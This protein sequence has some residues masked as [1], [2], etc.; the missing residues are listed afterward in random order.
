VFH[1][2][3]AAARH[4]VDKRPIDVGASEADRIEEG[5]RIRDKIFLIGE[6]VG[7][8]LGITGITKHHQAS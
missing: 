6:F 8:D 5:I 2:L 1:R 7:Y 4:V 3:L